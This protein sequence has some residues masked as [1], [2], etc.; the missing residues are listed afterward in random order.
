MK[1]ETFFELYFDNLTQQEQNEL[2]AHIRKKIE[3]I[4]KTALRE[5]VEQGNEYYYIS[6]N[7][8]TGKYINHNT[9]CG[10]FTNNVHYN[11]GNYFRTRDEAEFAYHKQIVLQKLKDFALKNNDREIDW[12]DDKQ[13]KHEIV[14]S[15]LDDALSVWDNARVQSIGDVYFTSTKVAKQAIEGIGEENITKYLFG[16]DKK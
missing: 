3:K 14:Y 9:E 7:Q 5:R 10:N 1:M 11:L 2:V 6:P 4:N 12:N 16:I 13:K 8:M 15:C